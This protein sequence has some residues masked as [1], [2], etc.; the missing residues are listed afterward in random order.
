MSQLAVERSEAAA[1]AK[2]GLEDTV[3]LEKQLVDARRKVTAA[4]LLTVCCCCVVPPL[5]RQRCVGGPRLSSARGSSLVTTLLVGW[6][7]MIAAAGS[8]R[9]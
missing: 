6:M 5:V 4:S 7:T 3:R 2:R 1:A 8:T 9:S